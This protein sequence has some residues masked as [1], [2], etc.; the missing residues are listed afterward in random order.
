MDGSVEQPFASALGALAIAGIL[1]DVGEQAC[2]EYTFA[3]V[4]GIKAAIEVDIGFIWPKRI[5]GKR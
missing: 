2:I 4:G 3:V 5:C 1:G